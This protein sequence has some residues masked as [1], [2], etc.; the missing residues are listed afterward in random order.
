M[1]FWRMGAAAAAILGVLAV[2]AEARTLK[3]S[4]QGDIATMDPYAHTESFTSNMHHH[5]YDPLVRRGRDLQIQSGLAT[6]WRIVE[7]NRW[8]FTLRPGVKFHNGNAFTADDVV[9]SVTRLLHPD[10]RARGNLSNVEKA[11][12]VDDLTVDFVLKGPYP[13]LLNDLTGIFIMDREWLEANNAVT[14]GNMTR[15]LTTFA[16]TNAN[17]TGPFMLESYRPDQ[18]TNLVVNPNWWDKAEHN[19]TRIEFRPIRSDA[20]RVA[21]LLSGEIDMMAPAPLQDLA[22]IGAADG[23][24]VVEE[25]S[26]RLIFLGFNYR[27]ELHGDPGKPN[28][29]KDKRVRQ[30]FSHAVDLAT[31]QSRIM[32]GKSRTVGTMVAPP[33]PGY[34]AALDAPLAFDAGKARA[35]LAEAGFPNGFKTRL[36]CSND[37][38]IADEQTCVAI[39]AMWTR[40]GVQVELKSQTRSSYFA[41]VDKGEADV[42]MLGWATL[43]PMDG[44]SVLSALMHTKAGAMGGNNPNGL[45]DPR[46]DRITQQVAVELDEPKR[47]SL[48]QEAFR[49]SREETYFLPLHQQPVSWAMKRNIEV[50][51]FADEYVRLWYAKVN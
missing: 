44:Y 47:L 1:A 25:P 3:W 18:G 28:P 35:L 14:P 36:D 27:D 34:V 7:P 49:I 4:S 15:N 21:A 19:L 41:M 17:G 32:R 24:K 16:S 51:V 46:L 26:L 42:Y 8:R 5:I 11:E 45:S 50:P 39:A 40:I 30:A 9:A 29:M 13:L 12:K 23:F 20:T 31:I 33:I 37:R 6:A 10:A 38:Y 43:P 48:M 22:R 2:G